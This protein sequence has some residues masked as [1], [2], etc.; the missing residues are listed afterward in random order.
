M[1]WL[2]PQRRIALPNKQRG[3]LLNTSR[4]ASAGGITYRASSNGGTT[5]GNTVTA[6]R[7]TGVISGD[8]LVFCYFVANQFHN[9]T[10][11]PSGSTLRF[12]N[13]AADNGI[14]IWTKVAG[15]S[16][17]ANYTVVSSGGSVRIEREF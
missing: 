13:T 14:Y 1:I 16:E 2:P 8:F 4:F 3:F 15:G 10:T 12:S 6:A 5:D 7:P 11:I 17:P 9:P